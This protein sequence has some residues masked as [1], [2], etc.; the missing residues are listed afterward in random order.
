MLSSIVVSDATVAGPTTIASA[1]FN[2]APPT[3][4]VASSANATDLV[5]I[6]FLHC[7]IGSA[8]TRY[9]TFARQFENEVCEFRSVARIWA[10][11]SVPAIVS[12]QWPNT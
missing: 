3:M 1:R 9:I 4:T 2:T 12:L 11:N 8:S 10:R 6:K 7:M 5:N